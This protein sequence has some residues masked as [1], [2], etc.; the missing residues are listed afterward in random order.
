MSGCGF[1]A[2]DTYLM[3]TMQCLCGLGNPPMLIRGHDTAVQCRQCGRQYAIV[4]ASLD[5]QTREL[6]GGIACVKGPSVPV[7]RPELVRS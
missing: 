1:V 2:F 6:K 4:E 7:M 5:P 3:A